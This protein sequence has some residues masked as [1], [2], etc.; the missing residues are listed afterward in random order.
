MIT[1][2]QIKFMLSFVIANKN[3]LA[4]PAMLR[5]TIFDADEPPTRA[6]YLI[7]TTGGY[8]L[9]FDNGGDSAICIEQEKYYYCSIR[10]GT[11]GLIVRNLYQPVYRSGVLKSWNDGGSLFIG[12]I[13]FTG[14]RPRDKK[15]SNRKSTRKF[16][17][18]ADI[19]DVAPPQSPGSP[20]LDAHIATQF[21]TPQS[22]PA[23]PHG[24]NIPTS[25]LPT[26]FNSINDAVIRI[27]MKDGVI[28]GLTFEEIEQ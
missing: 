12:D 23:K 5:V 4:I 24:V 28:V 19:F 2:K 13:D 25:I 9:R 11:A 10:P 26:I 22:K 3:E 6:A 7:R 27:T 17:P 14:L 8:E 16:T 1:E 20:R 18:R 15:I 21:P